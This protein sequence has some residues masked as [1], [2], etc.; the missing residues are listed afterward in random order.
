MGIQQ[1]LLGA[2]EFE[3]FC[4]ESVDALIDRID[5]KGNVLGVSA[6]T[7]IS[8]NKEDYKNIITAP[9]AY[10]QAMMICA[11]TEHLN[12]HKQKGQ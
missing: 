10:G 3:S 5:E 9:M 6:G 2:E 8:N 4:K 1:G 11:L 12:Y 7:A